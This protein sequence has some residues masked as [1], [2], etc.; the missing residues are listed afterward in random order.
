MAEGMIILPGHFKTIAG[1]L[2]GLIYFFHLA[3]FL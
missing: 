3:T 2:E 1:I